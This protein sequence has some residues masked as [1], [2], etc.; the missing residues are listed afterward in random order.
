[1]SLVLPP[2]DGR[3]RLTDYERRVLQELYDWKHP[4]D[5]RLSR[6]GDRVERT[7]EQIAARL[8]TTLI[9]ELVQRALP[10]LNGAATLTVPEALVLASF[11]RN[12]HSS[13]QSLEDIAALSLE[14]VETVVG[15]KRM[16]EVLKGS[17]EGGVAGFY[18][19]PGAVADVPVL[20]GLALRSVNV[21]A[22]SYGFAPTTDEERAHAL[23]VVAASAALGARTKQVSRAAIAFGGQIAGKEIVQKLLE[24]LPREL[25]VRLAALNTS[26]AAPL[27][28]AVTG[29]AFNG[30]FLQSVAVHARFA[31]RQRFL[32]RHHGPELLEAYGL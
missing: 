16:R 4:P 28:G 17:T 15:T 26:K 11:H 30:W 5:T 19:L 18:G 29:A 27:A 6:I 10:I 24:R 13:V 12:G 20:L 25:I 14:E 3:D 8:P 2:D 31:Y 9:D 21:F 1:M 22:A 23:S 7:I 32:E